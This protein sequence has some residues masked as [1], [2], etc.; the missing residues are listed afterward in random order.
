MGRAPL[1]VDLLQQ[2]PGVD[3][4][5]AWAR[6]ETVDWGG[7]PV[8]VIALTDLIAAKRAAGRD[9]DL[10]DLKNLERVLERASDTR[11]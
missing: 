2:A 5:V 8:S 11:R 6:R 10:L 7:A 1:R 3:F 4:A 9:Q